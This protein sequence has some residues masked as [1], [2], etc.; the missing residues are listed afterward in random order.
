MS[1][2]RGCLTLPAPLMRMPAY[3]T[4]LGQMWWLATD[5]HSQLN[6]EKE[7]MKLTVTL[8]NRL[9]LLLMHSW[10][11]QNWKPIQIEIYIGEG[12]KKY[13]TPNSSSCEMLKFAVSHF[14]SSKRSPCIDPCTTQ[15]NVKWS[16][17][18]SHIHFSSGWTVLNG[19][20]TQD[21]FTSGEEMP[22][23]GVSENLPV[24]YKRS[25]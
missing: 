17:I 15:L 11:R 20:T 16:I 23:A 12:R 9:N 18:D 3:K 19:C 22:V 2:F 24:A 1:G 4:R 7:L 10:D 14:Q 25:Q 13:Y 5:G 21:Q 6:G 8:F